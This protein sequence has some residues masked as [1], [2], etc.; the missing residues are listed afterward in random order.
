MPVIRSVW[1][2]LVLLMAL[3]GAAPARAADDF[4][5]PDVAFQQHVPARKQCDVDHAHGVVL[6]DDRFRNLLFYAQRA[7]APILEQMVFWAHRRYA[8]S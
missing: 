8:T 7:G 6:P 2:L 4:L 3:F 5:D 1:A